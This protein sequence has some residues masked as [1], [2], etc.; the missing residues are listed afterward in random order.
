MAKQRFANR[1]VALFLLVA[2]W[3]GLAAIVPAV[4]QQPTESGVLRG[5]LAPVLM[6]VFTPDDLRAVT[7][8]SD[9]TA[10]LWDLQSF[11]EVRQYKGHTGPLYCLALSADG[12]MLVTGAQDNTLRL[13]DV[14]QTRPLVWLAGHQ[15]NSN[16]MALSADGRQVV[17]VGAEKS[18]RLWEATK[19]PTNATTN[20]QPA[21]LTAF[22][23][24]LASHDFACTAAAYRGDGNLFATADDHGRI[25]F[26]SSYLD[27]PQGQVEGAHVTSLAFHSNNQQILA[28]GT[29]GLIRQWQLPIS[30]PRQIAGIVGPILHLEVMNNQSI[31]VVVTAD[32]VTRI[33]NLDT[34]QVVREIAKREKPIT[35]IR[36]S[37]NNALLAIGDEN[38]RV[39]LVNMANG[40]EQG[41]F[42][43][44]AGS[45]QSIRFHADNQQLFTTGVDGTIRHWQLPTAIVNLAGH[46]ES[47]QVLA[48][49]HSGQWYVTGSADKS[50]RVWQPN[51]Q[52]LRVLS[53]HQKPVTALAVRNDDSQIASGDAEGVIWLWNGS[54]GAPEGTFVGPASPVTAIA[55]DR[56]GS[57]LLSGDDQGWVRRWQ[58]P[59]KTPIVASGHSQA[60]RAL[61]TSPDGRTI[62]TG[63]LDQTVR[64]WNA[65]NG[66][67]IRTLEA[68]G[69]L[70]GAISSVAI[71]P[72]G[73]R[74][75]AASDAG[76]F[77]IWNL[78][79]GAL[80]QRRTG[81]GGAMLDIAF[82]PNGLQVITLEAD[83]A[84]RLWQVPLATTTVPEEALP[85][86]VVKLADAGS[87]SMA[88]SSDGKSLFVAGAAKTIAG[89]QVT[90]GKVATEAPVHTLSIAQGTI[91]DLAFS[92]DGKRFAAASE[93]RNVYVWDA[94]AIASAA[95]NQNLPPIQ[96]LTHAAVIR[97]IAISDD[98]TRLGAAGDDFLV[99]QWD[100]ATGQL[101]E[102]FSGH[103][104][105]ILSIASMGNTTRIASGGQD[106]SLRI[107][108]PSV[109][110]VLR[111]SPPNTVDPV[112][113]L[114]AT[115]GDASFAAL[116]KSGQSMLR[117]RADGTPMPVVASPVAG[118]QSLRAS[119]DG[120][121]LVAGGS[122]GKVLVWTAADGAL[123]ATVDTPGN[124]TDAVLNRAGN[125]V[126]VVDSQ[127][128]V[129]IC[130]V[131]SPRLLEEIT[132]P[133][134]VTSVQWS[135][136]ERQCVVTGSTPIGFI[137]SRAM[138]AYFGNF[139]EGVAPMALSPDG[140]RIL[141]GTMD[142]KIRQVLVSNGTLERILE[143]HTDAITDLSISAN[144]QQIASVAKDKSLR[145]WNAGDGSLVHKVDQPS[146]VVSV[147]QSP[148]N[149]RIAT[150]A[151]DGIV[152]VF[153]AATGLPLENF[154]NHMPGVA[155]VRWLS[156]SLTV[157]SGSIDQTLR[158]RKSAAV[159]TYR[160]HANPIVDM[161]LFAGG[162]QSLSCSADGRVVLCDTSSGQVVREFQGASGEPRAVASRV[163][164]Q[165]IALGTSDGKVLVW[166]ANNADLLQTL[167]VDGPVQS[168]VW[169]GDNA[170]LG[171]STESNKLFIFGPPLPPASPQ[172]GTEL[173]LHQQTNTE[174]V[175]TRL[176]FDRDNRSLWASHASG[177]LAKWAYAAPTQILQFNHGGPVYGVT[178][179]R[180]GKTI[181]SCSGDQTVRVWD[182]TTGQQKFQLNG[183]QGAV[184][185][186]SLSPDESFLVSSGADRTL[187]LWDVVGGRQLKQ[188]ATLNETMYSVAVH[189]NGQLVAA[190][191]ADR[192]V[193]LIDLISGSIVR[194]LES[195][196]DFIHCVA[197]NAIGTRLL[198]YGYAGQLRIWDAAAGN[199]LLQERIG[200]IGNYTEY[201][202]DGSRVL[203]SNGDSTARIFDIPPPAR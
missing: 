74:A 93:D 123:V 16:S 50:C 54:N 100:L 99:H 160:S 76:Q 30:E 9:D 122:Q 103:T 101:A 110:Q 3:L 142:G 178:T 12:R 52:P 155:Q 69:G 125:E 182:A 17:S 113:H 173:T 80:Q 186:L 92:R 41:S 136:E 187:R 14:P 11:S 128:R 45:I 112:T 94:A 150:C 24:L 106:N 48:R 139:P 198:S 181:Y 189:P 116:L 201:N 115:V 87:K 44:H 194:T 90:D 55:Y 130:S 161:T 71:S 184:H 86:Q 97:S 165:R 203:I 39:L 177:H 153:D 124:V 23:K 82:L 28:S 137:A 132:T 49:S 126:A 190:A 53:N 107:W 85:Y 157:V 5:H 120:N 169:S 64:V 202:S 21:D 180:D 117:W 83:N 72:D 147:S 129:R 32:Q 84:M 8:S 68:P 149:L 95:V 10:R 70:G 58:L 191:G 56:N 13:W 98:S 62:I 179:S 121:Q 18:S 25:I 38:G 131:A 105:P 57:S 151:E 148:N 33:I 63:S 193:Y 154:S 60:V 144:G 171:V 73:T 176:V 141:L 35:A 168:V 89:W 2:V 188:L 20:P 91:T 46:T 159:R 40:E 197:F 156:D 88:L 127:N 164:N 78:A 111:A 66:Q 81:T 199:L 26:R 196:T 163:D 192:K 109:S 29:D 175:A 31:A 43:G 15:G 135:S 143:G 61:V 36:L 172:P 47:I 200:R 67:A 1:C 6:G 27:E 119:P 7:A 77:A 162:A 108:T 19:L 59:A 75:A 34:G 195:H 140:A 114:A 118:L 146:T 4:G 65:E 79:D 96:T 145:I 42:S 104:Q 158:I 174:S 183:H 170:K 51:G 134:P 133:Q 152:R 22:S 167:T 102:R 138:R 185:A 166:N 37:P